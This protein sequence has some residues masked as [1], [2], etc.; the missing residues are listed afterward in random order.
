[1]ET[2][3]PGQRRLTIETV[4]EA[5]EVRLSIADTGCGMSEDV[6]ARIFEPFFTTKH[7][8]MGIGLSI[9]RSIL[10]AHGGELRARST[11]GEGSVFFFSLKGLDDTAR[12]EPDAQ[13]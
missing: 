7:A 3:D 10:D 2:T 11:V 8:G 9:C 13:T 1:M 5:E 4:E 6:L 12:P